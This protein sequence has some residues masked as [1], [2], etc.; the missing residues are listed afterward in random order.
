MS[1]TKLKRPVRKSC[2]NHVPAKAGIVD[3][4]WK[5]INEDKNRKY[6]IVKTYYIPPSATR[7][8][9]VLD[10]ITKPIQEKDRDVARGFNFSGAAATGLFE[11]YHSN[12]IKSCYADIIISPE[13]KREGERKRERERLRESERAEG[14]YYHRV[15][16]GQ[17][18]E[19]HHW[20]KW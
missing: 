7:G 20:E 15:D 8:I 6:Q 5:K 2:G 12:R 9:D 18:G 16:S 11:K 4:I 14:N 19:A 17:E 3:S 10:Q 1:R 13:G